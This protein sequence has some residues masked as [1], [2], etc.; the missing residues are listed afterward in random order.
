MA[1]AAMVLAACS[2]SDSAATAETTV[3]ET[4]ARTDSP[5]TTTT[6][7][8]TASP[9]TTA[10]T[11][12]TASPSTTT[13]TEATAAAGATETTE[14]TQPDSGDPTCDWNSGRLTSVDASQIPAAEGSELAQAI[15]GS[16]QRTHTNTGSGFE[17]VGP[18]IDIRFVLSADQFLYCQDVEGATDQAERSAPL[19]LEGAEIVLPSPASG[20]AVTAWTDDTMVWLNHFDGSLYLLQRR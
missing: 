7:E 12:T 14:T 1:M 19:K 3:T 6:T 13:A 15:L 2:G 9:S 4:T 10:A 5:S 18:T 16:W 8:T 11:E 20:Y 17:P